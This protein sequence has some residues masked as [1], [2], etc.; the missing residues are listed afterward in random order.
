[1]IVST[2]CSWQGKLEYSEKP[3]PSPAMSTTMQNVS[4]YEAQK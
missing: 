4:N 1:M 2:E 3:H